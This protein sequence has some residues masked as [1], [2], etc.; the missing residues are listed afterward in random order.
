M[1][2]Q[3]PHCNQELTVEAGSAGQVV[4]C[5][6]CQKSMTIPA[7]QPAPAA[8][9]AAAGAVAPA[10]TTTAA[11]GRQK[12]VFSRK[13]SEG[14][15]HMKFECPHCKQ[16][17]SVPPAA[18]G[19]M[20]Q[21]PSCNTRI[22]VPEFH[23]TERHAWKETDPTNPHF[24]KSLGIGIGL[25]LLWFGLLLPFVPPPGKAIA[26]YNTMQ[27]ISSLF[28]KHFV[29][30]FINTLFFTW[31]MSIIFMKHRKIRLQKDALLL[32]VLP[33]SLGRDIDANT[34]TVFID[35]VYAL[36]L[37]LRDSLMVNRIRKALELFEV[38]QSRSDVREMM[39]SQ[40]E[41]DSARIGG[42]YTLLRAFLWG[43]PLLGFIGT[44]V[45]LS[46]AIGGMNFAN[47]EDVGKIVGS[48]NNV[49]SGLGTAFDATLLGLVLALT[50][51]FPLN[52]LAKQE[53]DNL[54]TIDAFCNEVLLPRLKDAATSQTAES[55]AGAE[56]VA[57]AI[58]V[59]QEKFLVELG[60]LTQQMGE[61]AE[62]MDRRLEG[63]QQAVTA[64][65]AASQEK[66][67][68]E[69]SRLTQQMG[70]YAGKLDHRMDGFQRAVEADFA[71]KTTEMQQGNQAALKASA[72]QLVGFQEILANVTATKNE[73]LRAQ[74]DRVLRES[75]E[76]V[77]KYLGSLEVGIGGLNKVL[78]ELGEKQVTV[79]APP[80]RRWFWG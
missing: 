3:C 12:V 35:H 54:H 49:T 51:N 43:I 47:V 64:N 56:A 38:R 48:I 15:S 23:K 4:Q 52:A 29:V 78:T 37:R 75:S 22:K 60:Q 6:V 27:F 72:E 10:A 58:T 32:D 42:S 46:Q 62:K 34:V 17:L 30:S 13:K 18:D 61:H 40:S 76:R 36:P 33:T 41:I 5:P 45:G 74:T 70:E 7:E 53:D 66:F 21:C 77:A 63:F 26:E 79:N 73:E 55:G 80:K 1:K 2:F 25:L 65:F 31:A 39:A 28:Y 24:I 14:T 44:V 19:M 69:L 67:L 59:T 68:A 11:G 71:A 20:V 8:G 50:L 16:H 9:P 57:R